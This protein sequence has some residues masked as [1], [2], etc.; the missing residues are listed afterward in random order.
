MTLQE[1]LRTRRKIAQDMKPLDS[2]EKIW[3][4]ILQEFDSMTSIELLMGKIA[5]VD[6][7]KSA[8][9]SLTLTKYILDVDYAESNQRTATILLD[10]D[11]ANNLEDVMQEVARRAQREGCRVEV[12]K[13]ENYLGWAFEISLLPVEE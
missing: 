2:A 3:E 12:V 11:C 7:E 10:E 13:E 5:C 1:K 9:K 6:V 8:P 4:Y